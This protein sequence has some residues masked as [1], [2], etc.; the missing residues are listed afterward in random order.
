MHS[1]HWPATFR[2]VHVHRSVVTTLYLRA[3]IKIA[4]A[5]TQH[6]RLQSQTNVQNGNVFV[7]QYDEFGGEDTLDDRVPD[8]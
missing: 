3:L 1:G 7:Q 4:D 6:P 8:L 5:F 2:P